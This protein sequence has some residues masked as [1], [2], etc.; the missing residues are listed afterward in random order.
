MLYKSKSPPKRRCQSPHMDEIHGSLTHLVLVDKAKENAD[1]ILEAKKAIGE[2]IEE[3]RKRAKDAESK[4]RKRAGMIG[5]LVGK[6]VPVSQTEVCNSIGSPCNPNRTSQDDNATLRTWH[7][8]GPN[9]QVE[10]KKGILAHHE[11]LLRLDAVDLDRGLFY[12]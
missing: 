7:P 6:S 12:T 11:V 9:V 1:D 5:N 8:D 3:T 4:M 10:Q 2:K